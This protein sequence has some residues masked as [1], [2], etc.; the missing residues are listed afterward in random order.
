MQRINKNKYYLYR[1]NANL[2]CFQKST[3]YA[4]NKMFNGLPCRL[5]N[6]VGSTI[7]YGGTLCFPCCQSTALVL[8]PYK[9]GRGNTAGCSLCLVFLSLACFPP[10][11]QQMPRLGIRLVSHCFSIWYVQSVY[12]SVQS[13]LILLVSLSF[14]FC[15][16]LVVS[17]F[18]T[19][20]SQ[21][22]SNLA[23]PASATIP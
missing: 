20:T 23:L 13:L 8:P 3:Y 1:S 2:S 16:V 7:Q 15:N 19:D 6:L 11:M 17:C 5:A 14:F 21:S 10:S 4:G 18:T 22:G 9:R 12:L